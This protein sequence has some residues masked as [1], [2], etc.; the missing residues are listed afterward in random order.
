[1]RESFNEGDGQYSKEQAEKAAKNMQDILENSKP[2]I[3]SPT[4]QDYDTALKKLGVSESRQ[5]FIIDAMKDV[6]VRHIVQSSLNKDDAVVKIAKYMNS[7]M[8]RHSDLPPLNDAMITALAA[9][10]YEKLQEEPSTVLLVLKDEGIERTFESEFTEEEIYSEI[11]KI[12]PDFAPNDFKVDEVV[13]DAHGQKA[14]IY[15]KFKDEMKGF[16]VFGKFVMYEIRYPVRFIDHFDSFPLN[17]VIR[18][19]LYDSDAEEVDAR[20]DLSHEE[21]VK[22]YEGHQEYT[23]LLEYEYGYWHSRV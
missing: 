6:E 13:E 9:E 21:R 17:P 11:I 3:V 4:A 12:D 7:W 22:A 5:E 8:M 18:R 1:M 20:L 2:P 16:G 10:I 19:R 15:L 23:T 14:I